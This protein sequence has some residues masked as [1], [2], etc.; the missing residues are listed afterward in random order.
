VALVVSSRPGLTL[1]TDS[2]ELSWLQ[3]ELIEHDDS[4]HVLQILC[5]PESA[6]YKKALELCEHYQFPKY[7]FWYSLLVIEAETMDA[8]S[9]LTASQ[10]DFLGGLLLRSIRTTKDKKISLDTDQ[11]AM[12]NEDTTYLLLIA[13]LIAYIGKVRQITKIADLEQELSFLMTDMSFPKSIIDCRGSVIK[14]LLPVLQFCHCCTSCT[15]DSED[16][17][18]VFDHQI[19]FDYLVAS[20]IIKIVRQ[21]HP[22]LR[23]QI[24]AN[25]SFAF[26]W[27]HYVKDTVRYDSEWL[28]VMHL[29]ADALPVGDF[30]TTIK[31]CS[32]REAEAW[33]SNIAN[34]PRCHDIEDPTFAYI[35]LIVSCLFNASR[36]SVSTAKTCHKNKKSK[37]ES[38]HS[39]NSATLLSF[40]VLTKLFSQPVIGQLIIEEICQIKSFSLLFTE[41]MQRNLHDRFTQIFI[42]K[43]NA[44]S[45]EQRMPEELVTLGIRFFNI[46]NSEI[47][48][49]IQDGLFNRLSSRC[50]TEPV[51]SPMTRAI[52]NFFRKIQ[53]FDYL[54]E[55]LA[56]DDELEV[57]SAIP[58]LLGFK[59]YRTMYFIQID[60]LLMEI[61]QNQSLPPDEVISRLPVYPSVLNA[62]LACGSLTWLEIKHACRY[63]DN[64]H[65]GGLMEAMK[66]YYG[67]I[68][69]KSAQ[70]REV[71]LPGHFDSYSRKKSETLLAFGFAGKPTPKG[72]VHDATQEE[73]QMFAGC[74]QIASLMLKARDEHKPLAALKLIDDQLV[75]VRFEGKF[76]FVLSERATDTHSENTVEEALIVLDYNAEKI[77]MQFETIVRRNLVIHRCHYVQLVADN[78]LAQLFTLTDQLTCHH[79][80]LLI[81]YA[82]DCFCLN[83]KRKEWYPV[84]NYNSLEKLLVALCDEDRS[85]Q[86]NPETIVRLWQLLGTDCYQFYLEEFFHDQVFPRLIE[87]MTAKWSKEETSAFLA[88]IMQMDLKS[89]LQYDVMQ[90]IAQLTV[91]Q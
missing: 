23:Q 40:E 22:S 79:I 31:Q 67:S 77:S 56:S 32:L 10:F 55:K 41:L 36:K 87:K 54:I 29:I 17:L 12:L 60:A 48:S 50:A 70:T 46:G 75:A 26:D 34:H 20:F 5:E 2:E 15:E 84:I 47:N 42:D 73:T 59:T 58:I 24:T 89:K 1:P 19:V 38:S 61:A 82:N 35:K 18:I 8:N 71:I 9:T 16:K 49:A 85:F 33:L 37:K 39:D 30:I 11:S 69:R 62:L 45:S 66:Y 44:H 25:P 51:S 80:T 21:T 91:E 63:F 4:E 90:M 88:A 6:V 57:A 27:Q 74:V 72:F 7:L 86:W 28:Q 3:L 76:I 64:E 14:K 83:G 53:D 52:H 78:V 65:F 68:K 13:G 81:D 43:F